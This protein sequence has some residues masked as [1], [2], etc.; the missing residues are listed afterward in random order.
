[1]IMKSA[2]SVESRGQYFKL[3]TTCVY[4][5][6]CPSLFIGVSGFTYGGDQLLGWNRTQLCRTINPNWI[7]RLF[8]ETC[9]FPPGFVHTR[10]AWTWKRHWEFFLNRAELS[11]NWANSG[12]LKITERWIGLNLKILSL[13]VSCW[14]CVNILV[15]HTRGGCVAGSSPFTVMTNIFV[16]E[17]REKFRKNSIVQEDCDT[18]YFTEQTAATE[19]YQHFIFCRLLLLLLY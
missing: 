6:L 5:A 15:S 9:S 14:C 7:S 10:L 17:F 16:T 3:N 8:R 4:D 12:N 19:I 18:K 2:I 11:L 1:M 13:H